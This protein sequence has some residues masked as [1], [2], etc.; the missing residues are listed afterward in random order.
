MEIKKKNKKM[1][2]SADIIVFMLQ[3]VKREEQLNSAVF[4]EL[5]PDVLLHQIKHRFFLIKEHDLILHI[6][7]KAF[8][9]TRLCRRISSPELRNAK[10]PKLI[11]L[12]NPCDLLHH[13]KR[14]FFLHNPHSLLSLVPQK[15]QPEIH[16]A[17]RIR[18][19]IS[20]TADGRFRRFR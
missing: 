7:P 18:A 4:L 12:L 15:S 5:I 2:T 14:R 20:A 10:T 16:Q 11:A 19:H 13:C 8:S 9:I 1:M 6:L 3:N 17:A